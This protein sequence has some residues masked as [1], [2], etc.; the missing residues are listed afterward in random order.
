MSVKKN[1]IANFIGQGWTAIMGL[2]FL[3]MY[4]DYL[5]MESFGLIGIFV[6]M[7]AWMALLDMGMMPTL[8]REMALFTAGEHTPQSIRELLYTLEIIC[9]S[10]AVLIS[11]IM[12]L[13]SDY[14]ASDWIK[15]DS[16]SDNVVAN[17]LLIMGFVI[18]LRFCEGIY[19]GALYGLQKQV[20]YNVVNAII[21]TL[22]HGGVLG[23]L[24]WVSPTIEAF[25]LWQVFISLI[26]LSILA[27]KLHHVLPKSK[28]PVKF[29]LDSLLRVRKFAI[30]MMGITL[31]WTIQTQ[32][33]KVLLAHYLSL[34]NYG[35][36]TIAI[37]LAA[38]LFLIIGPIIQ[39]VYPMMVEQVAK[40]DQE[41]LIKD[42]HLNSQLITVIIA[43]I[44][45]VI[46]FYSQGVI[47][48]WSGNEDLALNA[49]PILS[50]LILGY[51][52][53]GL[54]ALPY[55]MQIA[56]NWVQLAL[57][58]NFI[59]AVAMVPILI[60]IVP[61]YGAVGAALVWLILNIGYFSIQ[62]QF[63]HRRL[64]ITEKWKW[65]ISDVLFPIIGVLIVL[66]IANLVS[67]EEKNNRI[68]WF[69]FLFFTT[70]LSFVSA[71]IISHEL[72]R[73]AFTLFQKNMRF[74][75]L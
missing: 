22:R 7:Q 64:L 59:G 47:Y 58:T 63:M 50:V 33:D 44:A 3:P 19:R 61:T 16:L 53:N 60:L 20:W 29:S 13:S 70:A 49:G 25:F 27:M 38:A 4:I 54:L 51:F 55:H 56:H 66:I 26:A 69:Y 42:Y 52:F 37:T 31:L 28:S 67:P 11:L 35:Y 46:S 23:I 68:A 30:G 34:E 15:A 48:V 65:Y 71:L 74:T 75:K 24:V 45:L 57:K 21:A 5:G 6:I 9:Y 12:W 73:R 10:L 32:F 18:A 41:N 40:N 62:I 14:L 2:I 17:A 43:P 39:A 8:N 1:I 72:R 36:Y